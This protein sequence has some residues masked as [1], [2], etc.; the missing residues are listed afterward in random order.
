M[1]SMSWKRKSFIGFCACCFNRSLILVLCFA[2]S[3]RGYIPSSFPR[4][5]NMRLQSSCL[6]VTILVCTIV[7]E[8]AVQFCLWLPLLLIDFCH[9][10]ALSCSIDTG[11]ILKQWEWSATVLCM[12]LIKTIS[13]PCS[14]AVT[15]GLE[16]KYRTSH[17][18]FFCL[19]SVNTYRLA[20]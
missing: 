9:K 13:G 18:R 3:F 14:Q 20:P 12:P 6:L 4:F 7:F 11:V 15:F 17:M 8:T 16:V 19:W 5:V 10:V 2:I 1:F